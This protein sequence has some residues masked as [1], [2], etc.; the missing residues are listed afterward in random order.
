MDGYQHGRNHGFGEHYNKLE[1]FILIKRLWL[2]IPTYI[3]YHQLAPFVDFCESLFEY[4]NHRTAY[5]LHYHYSLSFVRHRGND[6][7]DYSLEILRSLLFY[8]STQQLLFSRIF[9]D[10]NISMENT[11]YLYR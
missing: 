7:A 11:E 3:V 1:S 5:Y 8:L 9:C 6:L 2:G 4:Y 10:N